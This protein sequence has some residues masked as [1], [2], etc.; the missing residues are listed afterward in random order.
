VIA[1]RLPP[2]FHKEI[3]AGTFLLLPMKLGDKPIG[4]IYADK[5]DASALGVGEQELSVL[6]ALRDQLVSALRRK[7][8]SPGA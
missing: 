2:W 1:Q 5:E 4:A 3:R 6:K 7:A 8:S